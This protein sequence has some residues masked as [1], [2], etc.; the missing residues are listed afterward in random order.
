MGHCVLCYVLF[1]FL[2]LYVEF[3]VLSTM[4]HVLNYA[5]H[6]VAPRWRTIEERKTRV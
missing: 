3:S 4:L 5:I 6:E 1:N 2:L